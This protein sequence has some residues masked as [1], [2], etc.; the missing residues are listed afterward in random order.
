M[1]RSSSSSSSASNSAS[2]SSSSSEKED[3]KKKKKDKKEKK[4]KKEKKKDKAVKK[5][6]K[7]SKKEEKKKE[8]KKK[9]L[10]KKQKKLKEQELKKRG[11]LGSVTNQYG[12]YGVINEQDLYRKR[13][14]F[15]VW[16]MEVQKVA[17]ETLSSMEEKKLFVDFVED[18]NTAT[19]PSRKYYD[20]AA[21]DQSERAKMSKI[22]PK[23]NVMSSFDD[24]KNRKMEIQQMREERKE[25]KLIGMKD[26][27]MKDSSIV[28]DM[29]EQEKL[30]ILMNQQF[31]A[32]NFDEAEKIR[33]RIETDEDKE[34]R[35]R[36]WEKC[37][38]LLDKAFPLPWV[39]VCVNSCVFF[40]NL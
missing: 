28:N 4:G 29:R 26:E 22:E 38:T 17:Y 32:G 8:K 16:C 21:W 7:K 37:G 12:K 11:H 20:L 9:K 36:R 35:M 2:C 40:I 39:C 23:K 24:E 5:K 18:H 33:K 3:K 10:A 14:E 30:R 34:R 31:K 25:K 27:M 1:S 15:Q 19:F 13:P 6:D